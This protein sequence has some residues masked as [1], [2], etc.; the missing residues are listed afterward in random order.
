MKNDQQGCYTINEEVSVCVFN[1]QNFPDLKV[2]PD[3]TFLPTP[4]FLL[5]SPAPSREVLP[6]FMLGE[7]G[8]EIRF[9]CVPAFPIVYRKKYPSNY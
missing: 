6:L 9:L 2:I 1:S 7:A 5:F 3:K 8:I 4:R